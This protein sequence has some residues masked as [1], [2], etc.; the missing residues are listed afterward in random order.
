MARGAT[1]EDPFAIFHSPPLNETPEDRIAREIKESEAKRVSDEIDEQLKADRAAFKKQKNIVQ[2]LLLG[3]AESG[4]YQ[5]SSF[6]VSH[7][8]IKC[9]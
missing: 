3:Q 9:R 7:V 5:Q 1:D 6:F 8:L 4:E 2:V